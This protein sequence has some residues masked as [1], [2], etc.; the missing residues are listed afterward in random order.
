MSDEVFTV[1]DQRNRGFYQIDNE[2]ITVYA[3]K[4]KAN[5]IAVYNAL[6]YHAGKKNKAGEREVWPSHKTLSKETGMCRSAVI[7]ALEKLEEHGLIRIISGRYDEEKKAN[8][9]NKYI[10]L[11]LKDGATKGGSTLNTLPPSTLNTQGVVCENDNPSML[12]GLEQ[13]S[14]NKTHL[15]N[16]LGEET[17]KAA[18]PPRANTSTDPKKVKPKKESNP[19]IQHEAVQVYRDVFHFYPDIPQSVAIANQVKDLSRWRETCEEWQLNK[20]RPQSVASILD[21]Y[22]KQGALIDGTAKFN[23][24]GSL[25]TNG[26]RTKAQSEF[27]RLRALPVEQ[28]P[29]GGR[30]FASS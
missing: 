29:N 26:G 17:A 30:W 1:E 20:Y 24:R 13:D 16:T 14:F 23:G 21:R 15:N 18:P 12:N 25:A 19:H 10:L 4:I 11:S 3:P 7:K 2:L 28:Q 27:E 8:E 6:V 9:P 22:E 5:G